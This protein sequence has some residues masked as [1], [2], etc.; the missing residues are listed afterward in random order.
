MATPSGI[1]IAARLN[2]LPPTRTHVQATVIAGIGSFFDLFDIF[3][4]G[5]LGTVLTQRFGL[6]RLLLPVALSSAFVGMFIGATVARSDDSV[7]AAEDAFASEIEA[8]PTEQQ[9]NVMDTLITYVSGPLFTHRRQ[10]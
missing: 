2:R 1:S 10:P 9:G 8:L 4:A 6:D 5:V 7:S 3:L